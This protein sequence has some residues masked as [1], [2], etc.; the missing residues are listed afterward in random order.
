MTTHQLEITLRNVK[1]AVW[2]RVVVPSSWHL[3]KVSRVIE[4]AMGWDGYHLHAFEIGR[5]RYGQ[6]DPDWDLDLDD[7]SEAKLGDVL[8]EVK[9]KMRWDYDFGDGWEHDVLV[10]AIEESEVPLRTAICLAG[11][12]ACPP[13]DSG[14]PWGYENI[15]DAIADPT[16]PDHADMRDW[17]GE[18][19][20]PK[21]FDLVGTNAALQH[22]R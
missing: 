21:A 9:A 18:A 15:L 4:T 8:G 7:E 5:T 12:N 22:I 3:G 11:S 16:H 2:R 20:D 14:G 6:R 10:E 17:I 19:F 13:E 1:P